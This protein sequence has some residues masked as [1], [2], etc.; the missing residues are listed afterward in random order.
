MNRIGGKNR[1]VEAKFGYTEDSGNG[2]QGGTAIHGKCRDWNH[3]R[4][5]HA[6]EQNLDG[7]GNNIQ[8]RAN[9]RDVSVIQK[10]QKH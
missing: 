9:T 5:K 10:A 6:G 1:D 4:Q 3:W 2:S 8:E 7:L